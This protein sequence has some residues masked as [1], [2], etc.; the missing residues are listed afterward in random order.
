[1]SLKDVYAPIFGHI[2]AATYNYHWATPTVMQ[3]EPLAFTLKHYNSVTPENEMKPDYIVGNT[4]IT[5]QEAAQRGYHIPADY[6]E[7]HVPELNIDRINRFLKIAYE[8]NLGVRYHTLVWHS[9]TPERLFKEGYAAGG[10]DVAREVMERR[11]EMYVKSVIKLVYQG[12]YGGVVYAWDVVNEHLHSNRQGGWNR[13]YGNKND[14]VVSAFKYAHEALTEL[15]LRERVSLFYNDYNEYEVTGGIISLIGEINAEGRYCDGVGMQMHLDVSYPSVAA[16]G[17]TIDRFQAEGYEIQITELDVTLNG[18][19]S[20]GTRTEA[21]QAAYYGALFKLLA[22]KKKAG[23]N[24][25]SVT[26]WGLHDGMSWRGRYTPLLFSAVD[27]PKAALYN[28]VIA[29]AS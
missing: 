2:G 20:S 12:P 23:A 17:T 11:L 24:I 9:Q 27:T 5:V 26:M 19:W 7:T 16:I 10:S 3:G 18:Q 25:T 15:G 6:A 29:A 4:L 28:A 13:I 22:D 14:F 8:N 1:V 21:D